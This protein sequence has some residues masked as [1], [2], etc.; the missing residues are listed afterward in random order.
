MALQDTLEC[1][2]AHLQAIG[3]LG[4]C[5]S[6]RGSLGHARGYDSSRPAGEGLSSIF[7]WVLVKLRPIGLGAIAGERA[8]A[9]AR[10]WTRG[11]AIVAFLRVG[12][13]GGPPRFHTLL[14]NLSHGRARGGWAAFL[15]RCDKFPRL[16]S[17]GGGPPTILEA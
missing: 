5:E 12:G 15:L 6:G 16:G 3:D 1:A 13:V 11:R 9:G 2:P 14:Y 4:Q 8:G 17:P 7:S 10:G